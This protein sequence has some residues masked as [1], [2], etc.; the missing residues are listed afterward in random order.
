MKKITAVV[1]FVVLLA[2]C[3]PPVKTPAAPTIT[4]TSAQVYDTPTAAP[5]EPTAV[6]PT[7][8][9]RWCTV[10]TGYQDGA[11]NIRSGPGMEHPVV[12]VAHEGEVLHVWRGDHPI[13]GWV[14]VTTPQFVDGWFYAQRWCAEWKEER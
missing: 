14:H 6:P 9:A 7:D 8:E 5:P 10:S 4:A 3:L 2:G 11:V 13:D 1:C 12:D